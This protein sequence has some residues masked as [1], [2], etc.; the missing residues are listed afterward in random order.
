METGASILVINP[1]KTYLSSDNMNENIDNEEVQSEIPSEI[2]SLKARA[3][4]M[5]IV[6]HPNIGV[7]KL[8]LK[9][10]NA[11][12]GI[13]DEDILKD[14]DPAPVKK[15]AA[16]PFMTHAEYSAEV[17]VKARRNINRLVRCNVSCMNPDKTEWLGEIISVG[18][19]KLGTFKKYIPFNTDDGYHI[20]NIIYQA[21]L[22][23]KF[24]TYYTVQGPLGQKIRKSK[25]TK[26]FNVQKMDPLTKEEL[27]DLRQQQAL[28]G[29]TLPQA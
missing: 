8:K 12:N 5:G 4:M 7:D 6:F 13:D 17:K 18:S 25:L 29:S 20:P 2:D 26:E 15:S 24:S 14:L 3:K 16:P 1:T 22:E 11:L 9:I 23:R 28:S 19:A 21:L 10:E 27:K